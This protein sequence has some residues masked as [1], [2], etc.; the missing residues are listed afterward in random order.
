MSSRILQSKV[1]R[2]DSPLSSTQIQF[3]APFTPG[4][5]LVVALAWY[6]NP[7]RSPSTLGTISDNKGHVYTKRVAAHRQ[8]AADPSWAGDLWVEIHDC[9]QAT[10]PSPETPVRI[11]LAG[12]AGTNNRVFAC[13][14]EVSN[15]T[16]VAGTSTAT[17]GGENST[18]ATATIPS[19]SVAPTW[20]IGIVG[21]F[22]PVTTSPANW[23][24][25]S[26]PTSAGQ[27]YGSVVERELASS[28]PQA[29]TWQYEV[30][31]FGAAA[32][33]AVYN[34]GDMPLQTPLLVNADA[35]AITASSAI[36]GVFLSFPLVPEPDPDPEPE[37]DPDPP[38]PGDWM[39]RAF[40]A[41][42]PWNMK[43]P[44]NAI[45][46]GTSDGRTRR[47]RSNSG[48][49]N[50]YDTA[51]GSIVWALNLDDYTIY[52]WYAKNTD[53]LI[54]I[55]DRHG[56]VHQV[57]CPANAV[58]STGTDKHMCII[59][60]DGLHSHDMW[61]ATRHS[62]GNITTDGYVKVK[63]DRMGWRMH[64]ERLRTSNNPRGLNTENA[65]AGNG[66]PRAVSAALLGGLIRGHHLQQGYIPHAL[67]MAIP[68]RWALGGINVRIYPADFLIGWGDGDDSSGTWATFSGDIRYSDRFGLDKN[69]DVT[70]LGLNREW[71]IIARAL[72]EYGLYMVDVAGV[73]NPCLYCEYPAVKSLYP[74]IK[75]VQT[76]SFDRIIPHMMAVD[77]Y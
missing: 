9:L 35:Q 43:I 46:R 38:E 14:M 4:S 71:T 50:H 68:R 29:L 8:P 73:N 32:V 15:I 17:G 65:V 24:V 33:A 41:D 30:S 23:D 45:W 13:A 53:P 2:L 18:S 7:A 61:L 34:A 49:G 16:A 63:L 66:G 47:I 19:I 10:E 12:A 6:G 52:T 25:V 28:G 21:G 3:D 59:D 67:A 22:V 44:A 31:L 1:V 56:G 40:A 39:Q 26:A 5:S 70:T 55:T 60:P 37:P 76:Y 48:G 51:P 36:P 72:Q 75:S 69:I 42:S 57:R 20:G 54:T 62:N 27:L 64:E 58:P 11:T 77:W 74:N